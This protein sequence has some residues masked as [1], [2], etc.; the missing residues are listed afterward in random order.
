VAIL[1]ACSTKPVFIDR[2]LQRLGRRRSPPRV[3]G[4][5]LQ[6]PP[7]DCRWRQVRLLARKRPGLECATH[8][9]LINE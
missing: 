8:G 9:D 1:L 5:Q 2:E 3:F 7:D 4:F 6:A